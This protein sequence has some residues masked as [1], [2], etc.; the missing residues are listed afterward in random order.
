MNKLLNNS[1]N[2]EL[3]LKNEGRTR[4]NTAIKKK[5][6]NACSKDII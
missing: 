5:A 4:T 3:V 2:F 1:F 6:E